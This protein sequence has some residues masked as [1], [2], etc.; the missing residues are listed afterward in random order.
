[1]SIGK[2]TKIW[3]FSHI[4]S[5]VRI[6]KS[7][8]LGQNINVSSDVL[9]GDNVKIQNNVSVY[10]GVTLEDYVFC[11]PSI[12]FTNV[13]KPRSEFPKKKSEKYKKTL[14]KKSATIGANATI[15][16]GITIGCYA[17]VGAGSVVLKDVPNFSLVVGNPGRL[18]GWVNEK[19]DRLEFDK[20]GNSFCKRFVFHD[21]H[22]D[23][24]EAH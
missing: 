11:G 18:I 20:N 16:C 5:N 17:I 12:V 15:M 2:N 8:T 10:E 13:L 7:C 21:N 9:I 4:Q 3:H 1:M 22:V 24:V 14:V 6:G 19:G 23:L